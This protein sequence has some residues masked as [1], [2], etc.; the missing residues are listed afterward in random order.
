MTPIEITDAMESEALRVLFNGREGNVAIGFYTARSRMKA[1][2]AAGFA[3]GFA[4]A[5][6]AGAD[7]DAGEE[8]F[9]TALVIYARAF[10]AAELAYR[11]WCAYPYDVPGRNQAEAVW[12]RLADETDAHRRRVLDLRRQQ[13]NQ[14]LRELRKWVASGNQ[15][16]VAQQVLLDKIDAMLN[17]GNDG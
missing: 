5:P 15:W 11:A 10:D 6:V 2:L 13:R 12:T 17:G 16:Y 7:D 8:R 1:A 14:G 9:S 4:A 3:A